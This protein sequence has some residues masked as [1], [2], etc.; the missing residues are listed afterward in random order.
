MKKLFE[1]Y[2]APMGFII[3]ILLVM[4]MLNTN[5]GKTKFIDMMLM[6]KKHI[7]LASTIFWF[8]FIYGIINL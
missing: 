7:L 6:L 8:L 4:F 1:I 2:N 3:A 5:T